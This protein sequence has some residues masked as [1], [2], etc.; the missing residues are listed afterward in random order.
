MRFEAAEAAGELTIRAAV[1]PLIQK[2]DDPD[3]DV[4]EAAALALGKIGGPTARRALET[5][6]AGDDARLAEAAVE[7]LEELT[8]NSHHLDDVLLDYSDKSPARRNRAS[9]SIEDDLAISGDDDDFDN[10]DGDEATDDLDWDDNE[11]EIDDLDWD[12]DDIDG[13]DEE[14]DE[15]GED[16]EDTDGDDLDFDD[17]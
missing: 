1:Q 10:T 11:D 17:E 2:L 15:D 8:F 3:K 13:K 16:D 6:V 4:R 12:D 7:A 5:L 14:D 9:G